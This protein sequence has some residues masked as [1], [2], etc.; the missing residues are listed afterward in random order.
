MWRHLAQS[1]RG[2]SHLADGSPCQDSHAVRLLGDA[3]AD[4]FVACIADGAGSAKY[5][6]EGAALACAAVVENAVAFFDAHAG[7]DGLD[8][9]EVLQWCEDA[10]RRI[11]DNADMSGCSTREFAT[12]LCVAIV[13]PTGSYFFQ[14][15][16]GAIILGSKGLYG[17]VF[18]P[19]SGEYA[20]STNFLTAR[21]YRERLEFLKVRS[22]FTD[23]ALFTDGMERLALQFDKQTPHPPFFQPLFN[24]LRSSDDVD[25]LNK[26][27]RAFLRSESV[28]SRSDDDKTLV[29]AALV[30]EEAGA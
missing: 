22:D 29:L 8:V 15:G 19:Q 4:T 1:L 25:G 16:D 2:A 12:T 14:I 11:K 20:N 18:W 26:D 13:S 3:S 30:P 6:D 21:E 17:V 28:Q 24:A 23:L 27:F 7:F 10:R 9:D 5:S